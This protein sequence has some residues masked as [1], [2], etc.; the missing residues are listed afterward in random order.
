MSKQGGVFIPRKE[1]TVRTAYIECE[2]PNAYGE[3]GVKIYGVWSPRLGITSRICTHVDTWK[4]VR[5]VKC[6]KQPTHCV[7]ETAGDVGLGVVLQD[8]FIVPWTRGNNCPL[9]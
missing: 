4:K 7:N 5:K 8:G 3:Q 2:A 6:D 1:H 9:A